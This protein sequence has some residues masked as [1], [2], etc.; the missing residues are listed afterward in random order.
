MDAEYSMAE[1]ENEN[2]LFFEVQ[3]IFAICNVRALLQQ[4]HPEKTRQEEYQ[5][6]HEVKWWQWYFTSR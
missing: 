3:R 4:K 6:H 5:R 1:N 2:K